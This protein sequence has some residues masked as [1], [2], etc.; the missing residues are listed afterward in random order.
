MPVVL[1]Q[2]DEVIWLDQENFDTNLLQSL[3]VPYDHDQM[4]AYPEIANP[5]LF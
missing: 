2:Q 3:L 1:R 4:R 5:S